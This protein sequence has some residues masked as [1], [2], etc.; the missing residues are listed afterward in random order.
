MPPNGGGIKTLWIMRD[1]GDMTEPM[2]IMLLAAIAKQKNPNRKDHLALIERDN[3]AQVVRDFKPDIVAGSAITGA[4]K[5]YLAEFE[6]LKKEFGQEIFIILGGPY[7]STYPGVIAE[8]QYL[9]A[10]GVYEC[11]DAWADFLDAFE[12]NR[13]DIHNIPNII[14]RENY[15]MALIRSEKGVGV[16]ASFYR[17]RRAD[18]DSLPYMDRE[19]IYENTAF[20][21]RFK[22]THMAGRGCPFRCTYCFE[23]HWN[24]IYRAE[25]KG[26]VKMLQRYS[27]VRFCEELVW[28]MKRWDTRFWKFYDDVFPTFGRVDTEWL[29]EFAEVYPKMVGLPFHCLTRCDIVYRNPEALELLKKAGIGSLTM[30][31]ESGNRYIRDHVVLRDMNEEQMRFSFSEAQKLGIYTFA[32]TILG[33]PGPILPKES[34]AGF[35]PKIDE[36]CKDASRHRVKKNG[37][38]FDLKPAIDS[39]RKL[40]EMDRDARAVV[41]NMLKNLNMHPDQ[42]SYDRESCAFNIDIGVSFGEFPILH[43]YPATAA[44]EWLMEKG[45]FDGDYDKLHSSYQ[46]RSPLPCF[47]EKEKSVQQNLALLATFCMLFSGSHNRFMRFL[48]GPVSKLFLGRLSEIHH[49][50]A[51]WI[52]EQLYALSKSYMHETRIY[53]MRRSFGEKWRF[54]ADMYHLDFWKQFG[55]KKP[56]L[57]GNRPGQTLGG[58]PSV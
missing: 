3:I 36:I 44:T 5:F 31:I 54:Y 42:I 50:W 11:D 41:V 25:G 1:D 39:T 49:P 46:N 53:P 15:E 17:D 26:K 32:N 10:I 40:Y 51:T 38:V 12:R 47:T 16:N 24:E 29:R 7:C 14:T 9:D 58:P 57:R 33:I 27:P 56:L 6:R 19:L 21:T 55:N 28:V 48:S 4:H 30:S 23:E 20:K 34:D 45:W 35:W 8:R 37:A 18:F 13:D 43:P 2:N 52:Y 22:R